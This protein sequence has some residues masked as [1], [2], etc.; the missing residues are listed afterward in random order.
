MIDYAA[1]QWSGLIKDYY[2]PRWSMF[3]DYLTLE[4][5]D[6]EHFKFDQME[7]EKA[8]FETI[9][10]PF[11]FASKEYPTYVRGESIEVIKII[12]EKWRPYL[13]DIAFRDDFKDMTEKEI[14]I[15][16]IL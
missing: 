7:F 13:N 12:Y 9:E 14:Q 2:L 6:P 15:D 8:A 11:T 1:K 16:I 5:L 10:E 4:L 3:L